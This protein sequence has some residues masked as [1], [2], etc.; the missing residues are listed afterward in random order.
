MGAGFG[1]YFQ[2]N[3]VDRKYQ[4]P[5]LYMGNI[6][7]FS[8]QLL[9]YMDELNSTD[10]SCAFARHLSK[11][12]AKFGVGDSKLLMTSKDIKY[13]FKNFKDTQ[14]NL[15]DAQRKL[16]K[17]IYSLVN[18]NVLS[19]DCLL[20]YQRLYVD[21]RYAIDSLYILNENLYRDINDLKWRQGKFVYSEEN[22][23]VDPYLNYNFNNPI[24]TNIH[25][26]KLQSGDILLSLGDFISSFFA[27]ITEHG[28]PL[29]HSQI[30]YIP[31]E[32]SKKT[33]IIDTLYEQDAKIHEMDLQDVIK[34][35]SRLVIYRF[36]NPQLAHQAAKYL[37]EQI[38]SKAEVGDRI[39]FDLYVN[40]GDDKF[41]CI[42]LIRH[43]FLVASHDQVSI[44]KM[45]SKMTT[46]KKIMWDYVLD[47]KSPDEI[48]LPSDIE[49]DDRFTP[50]AEIRNQNYLVQAVILDAIAQEVID[51]ATSE[52]FLFIYKMLDKRY[53]KFDHE[54]RNVTIANGLLYRVN[55]LYL[56][57]LKDYIVQN[58]RQYFNG[59]TYFEM[60]RKMSE[61]K[62]DMSTIKK[63]FEELD[64]VVESNL[65]SQSLRQKNKNQN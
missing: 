44:P 25:S 49:W 34:D 17:H 36:N 33:Y 19:N 9:N 16:Q 32:N 59:P 10:K 42:E 29:A 46:K 31:Q 50:V 20:S 57:K 24:N 7:D 64:V 62:M 53:E 22:Q 58:Q 18:D 60:R 65:K 40:P 54:A 11:E 47:G 45:K 61:S 21:I 52:K 14:L 4:F 48:H 37:F 15:Q 23:I 27:N 5:S 30:V 39:P 43:A 2:Y 1:L 56:E 41:S 13:R 3:S 8:G 55:N 28:D 6:F 38:N 26:L 51:L 12:L 63:M 35:K